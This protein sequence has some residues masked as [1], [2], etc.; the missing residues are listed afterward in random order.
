MW[1]TNVM[2]LTTGHETTN[3]FELD[4]YW[5][6]SPC[7]TCSFH[8]GPDPP[9]EGQ[10]SVLP[11]DAHSH[12]TSFFLLESGK[13]VDVM[14]VAI[15]PQNPKPDHGA[16]LYFPAHGF[17]LQVSHRFVESVEKSLVMA[18]LIPHDG[19]TSA[20]NFWEVLH[21][22]FCAIIDGTRTWVLPEPHDYFGG[23]LCRNIDWE[24]EKD[25]EHAEVSHSTCLMKPNGN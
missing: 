16:L 1:L 23:R 11:L 22:R 13:P 20:K 18:Q 7:T 8:L 24:P 12:G 5:P 6:P 3:G 9:D 10:R 2:S 4:E 25:P 19:I 14:G 17:C 21:R 15:L